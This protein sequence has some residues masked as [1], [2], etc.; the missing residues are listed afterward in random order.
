MITGP[1][2]R[3]EYM[4][5]LSDP[6]PCLRYKVLTEL[7]NK[8]T[9]DPEVRDLIPLLQSDRIFESLSV[10]SPPTIHQTIVELRRLDFLGFTSEH[11]AVQKR[12]EYLFSCQKKD[13]SWPLR[14][15]YSKTDDS[16][17]KNPGYSMVPLQTALPLMAL[18]ACG[19]ATDVRVAKAFEWLLSKRLPD[20]GWPS[21]RASGVFGYVAGYRKL[22]HSRGGCRSNTTASVIALSVH[23]DLCSGLEV[24]RGLDLLLGRETQDV[25]NIGFETAR[26]I[27]AEETRGFFT[28]FARFDP[29][30]ILELC[31]RTGIDRSDARV[32]ALAKFLLQE[33]GPN[34]LWQYPA[35]R[36]ASMWITYS[37]LRSLRGIDDGESWVGD[38]PRTPFQTYPKQERRW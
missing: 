32:E 29:A 34:G 22:P 3:T 10:D 17:E 31:W 37:I 14:Q 13:G 28:Y 25:R 11:P 4:L 18:T 30:L 2:D 5:L 33:R 19:Y 12:A 7:F 36:Q 21:G 15:L 20:G 16:D 27:G 38:E 8:K 6:S 1:L 23:P 24:R 9:N 35:R 26:L